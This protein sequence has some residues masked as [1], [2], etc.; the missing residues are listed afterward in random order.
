MRLKKVNKNLCKHK[1]TLRV[2]FIRLLR[3]LLQTVVGVKPSELLVA[4]D[5]PRQESLDL[6]EIFQIQ[7]VVH[8]PQGNQGDNTRWAERTK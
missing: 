7:V 3:I 4:Q 8:T 5:G 6:L 2:I 1:W